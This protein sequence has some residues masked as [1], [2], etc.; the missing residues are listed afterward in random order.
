MGSNANALGVNSSSFGANSLATA[1]NS[2]ALG[3]GSVANQANTVSVGAAG[4]ERRITNVAAGIGPTDAVN[5]QQLNAGLYDV[6][7]EARRG[8]AAVAALPPLLTPSA[9]GRFTVAVGGGFYHNQGGVGVTAA[10]RFDAPIPVYLAGSY[11]NG[12]GSANIFRV[13]G[14]V[15]F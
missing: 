10:Y 5:V 14:G 7:R 3:Q 15:E 8:I 2:V 6:R 4:A 9:P 12:G 13:V 1:P 11:A